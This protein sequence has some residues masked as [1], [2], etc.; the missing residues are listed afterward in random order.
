M[1]TNQE[2]GDADEANVLKRLRSTFDEV[3]V[4]ETS[5]SIHFPFLEKVVDVDVGSQ[6]LDA[7]VTHNFVTILTKEHLY[8]AHKD[9]L[10]VPLR[11]VCQKGVTPSLEFESAE[12]ISVKSTSRLTIISDRWW[13]RRKPPSDIILTS[14]ISTVY[15]VYTVDG[16]STVVRLFNEIAYLESGT[17]K[18]SVVQIAEDCKIVA[19]ASGN[20]HS[21]F[22]TDAGAVFA[23]GTGSRGELGIGLVPRICEMT[24]LEALE[25]LKVVDIVAAGW[26]SGALTD[27]GDVYLWGWNHRGQLGDEKESVEYYPSPLEIDIRIVRIE[28]RDHLTALWTAEG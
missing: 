2:A 15:L 8:I 25:G 10:D 26:H 3:L 17:V 23:L 21:L 1:T 9:E 18:S 27:D 24:W 16:V 20:D 22:L 14:T 11:C 13:M 4:Y 28:M 12:W 19:A 5:F 6:V 7:C